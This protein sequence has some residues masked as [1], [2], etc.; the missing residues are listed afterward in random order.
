[1]NKNF[2]SLKSLLCESKYRFLRTVSIVSF[3]LLPF[4]VLAHTTPVAKST[5]KLQQVQKQIKGTIKDQKGESVPF[6]YV[7][8]K[9]ATGGTV[10]D[11]LGKY[12]IT[13]NGDVVLVFSYIGYTSIELSTKGKTTLDVVLP[14]ANHQ[15][16]EVVVTGYNQVERQHV[17]SAIE[18]VDMDLV[19]SRP[20]FKLEDGFIGT[21]SGVTAGRSNNVPGEAGS[22][23]IRGLSTLQNTAPLVIVDGI[24][25]S[26]SDIDPNQIKSISVLKDAASASMYG[27]R[28]A[29]G[30]IIIETERGL[31]GDFKVMVNAWAAIQK[32]IDLPEL[33]GAA[34][35][36]KL[37][38]EARQMQGQ[39][40]LLF[41]PDQIA[42]AEKGEGKNT[43]W[44]DLV[45]P[46]TAHSYNFNANIS[47]GGGVGMFNLMLG[48]IKENGLNE[49]VGTEKYSARFNTNVNF[50]ENFILM[51]D[52]Y[53]HR[54]QVNRLFA[55]TDGHGLF[56]NARKMNPTQA[57]YYDNDEL[58]I[59]EHYT[60]YNN[61]NPVASMN[62]GGTWNNLH[63]RITVNLRPRYYVFDG[64][65]LAGDLS[66]MINKSANKHDRRTFKFFDGNG[67]PL[68]VWAHDVASE[69]GVS[70]SQLTG[71]VTAN[72]ENELRS[73]KDKLY[74]VIG[75]EIM[76]TT[77]TDYRE[78]SKASFFGKM[79]YSFDN[80]YLLEV[81]LRRDGSSKFAPGHQW[82]F[83][84]SASLGWNLHNERFF[85][86]IKESGAINNMKLRLS[87]GKIGNENV[88]PYLWQEIVNTWGWTM[89]VPNPLF[90][91][92]KQ[93]QWNAGLDLNAF[94]NRFSLTFDVY[95]KF[96]YDLIYSNFPVPPLTGSYYLESAVNIG[97]VRNKGW[98]ISVKW[99]DKIGAVS[100]G[101]GAMLFD[102]VNKVE[103]AG[104]SKDD[105]L[106]FKDNA[107]KVWYRG[108]P[109]D[110]Y[111]GYQTNGFFQ[112][113][114]EVA[115]TDARM[116]NTLPGDVKYVDQNQDGVI[117]DDDKVILGSP[118]PRYNY[119]ININLGYKRWDLNILGNGIGKRDGW[120][121]GI[122]GAYPVIMDGSSNS[123]GTP[124]VET[125]NNRWT[126]ENPNSRFP[127]VWTGSST[128]AN[129]S[130][131][132]MSDASYF[133]IQ[134]LQVGYTFPKLTKGISNLRIFVNAQDFLTF[135][136]WEGLEPERINCGNGSYPRMA[137]YSVGFKVTLF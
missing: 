71:R 62:R 16:D 73:G 21:V 130:D 131:V 18:T 126:P 40:S 58:D 44:T 102:N 67:R 77:Y 92:E 53:A 114:E 80:R 11:E 49:G 78:V 85:S 56:Q 39:S 81:T 35:Y 123:L 108:V 55:N 72:Y 50:A 36:M 82:G 41:T 104:Y 22:L 42:A 105:V 83:F 125:M 24:E 118:L 122:D 115:A 88:D 27:S 99:E 97:E 76:S 89:R 10:S 100:Y 63:D 19:K 103:K 48:Y 69:Q 2:K 6:A 132:Y 109:I 107:N 74:A 20:V 1:M 87:Y 94:K 15:L 111:Y 112:T 52:F 66:Y 110:N 4:I 7:V 57:V 13:V 124:R 12:E 54:L 68:D 46:K 60:Y 9:G 93:K 120:L 64:F 91:W 14:E 135:T 30:V 31:T 116:P 8:V 28:G 86:S 26:M 90:S 37:N 129:L 59:D 25:Q 136:K 113:K 128:N 79:N 106:I 43:N 133:R 3:F 117:N 47:G 75:S 34:D 95:D 38:N 127:R 29:N 96:S 137:T 61:L 70:T 101:I 134:T 32:P 5:E 45:M 51:A 119:S 33:V 17:A 98:E 23:S 65:H 84:P 121:N